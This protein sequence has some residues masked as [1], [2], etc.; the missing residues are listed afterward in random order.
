MTVDTPLS[1]AI[2]A[3]I[4]EISSHNNHHAGRSSNSADSDYDYALRLLEEELQDLQLRQQHNHQDATVPRTVPVTT[5]E[6][7]NDVIVVRSVATTT[8]RQEDEAQIKSDREFAEKLS[9]GG[10]AGG[11]KQSTKAPSSSSLETKTKSASKA[12]AKGHANTKRAQL[13]RGVLFGTPPPKSKAKTNQGGQKSNGPKTTAKSGPTSPSSS[14]STSS[15]AAAGTAT[16]SS[17]SESPPRQTVEEEISQLQDLLQ[18]L[19]ATIGWTQDWQDDY[20]STSA[21]ATSKP[22]REEQSAV[23]SICGDLSQSY[24]IFPLKCSHRYCIDCLR[25]HILHSLSQP[26]NQ[27]PRC[28]G[29]SLPLKNAA[30]A[31]M[32]TELDTLM[33][34]CDA[35]ESSKQVSC[36]KCKRDILQGYIKDSSAYCVECK[37]FTCTHCGLE[38]HDGICEEDKGMEMLLDT[39]RREGWSKCDKCNHL[40]EL[41]VGC[42]HMTCRCGHHFCYLCGKTWKTCDCPSSSEHSVFGRLKE[43]TGKGAEL[44]RQ[45]WRSPKTYVLDK[46]QLDEFKREVTDKHREKMDLRQSLHRM[47]EEKQWERQVAEQ[48]ILLRTE[49]AELQGQG[50][51]K[52][53][54]QEKVDRSEENEKKNKKGGKAVATKA[55]RN[56]VVVVTTAKKGKK[57][58]K[59]GKE[60]ARDTDST[61]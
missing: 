10:K 22:Y 59:K 16:S 52:E 36:A 35:Y 32:S 51:E 49:I 25:D 53:Q 4:H 54:G 43:A 13:P 46:Q 44:L 34:R 26:S 9:R 39:A 21:H 14:S 38:L 56:N 17:R 30:E 18:I 58:S 37:E 1:A 27:P 57:P 42:F 31:L 61:D 8:T 41:T 11:A 15:K 19:A 3:Q 23:C 48:I 45:R 20:A 6:E 24:R 5:T 47:S 28:C 29:E 40:V 12:P 2:Q 55:V 50:K 60:R 33:D 7:Y